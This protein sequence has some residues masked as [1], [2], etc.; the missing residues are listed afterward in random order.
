MLFDYT[1]LQIIWWV[2]IAAVLVIYA[3]TAGFDFGV[4]L[5]MPFLRRKA[6]F[7]ENDEERRVL[8]NTIAPTWDGNQTWL[9]FAGG[10]LF[11][12]WP[13]V[14][15]ATFSGMYAL[16]LCVLWSFFLRP[17]GFDYRSKLPNVNWRRAW[18][19]GL[20][21]SAFLPVLAFGLGMGN[22][23]LGLPI[24]HDPITLRSFYAGN[25]GDLLNLFGIITMVASLFLFLMHGA[26]HLNRR[27]EGA[28]K[29]LFRKM[30]RRF[31][32]AFLLLFSVGWL[33]LAT[34]INGYVYIDAHTIHRGIGV[35]MDNYAQYPW[36][37][38]GPILAY[39]GIV[40]SLLTNGIG[41]GSVAFWLS[42][43]GVAGAVLTPILALFPFV[44]P[45]SVKV[46]QSLTIYNATSAPFTMMG[47]FYITVI[48]LVVIFA[49]KFWGYAMVWRKKKTLSVEDV[50]QHSHHLY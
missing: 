34:N 42:G 15:G 2:L 10:A 6:T 18:D 17:P 24:S 36:K 29:I 50:R 13:P 39:A 35:W 19:W 33:Q 5:L 8:L 14:Y 40:L 3:T 45:S 30:Q 27:T 38:V 25:F 20:F 32:I 49:Y 31:G 28:L 12:I 43:I 48:L 41:R 11:V 4:T 46:A 21:I 26:A 23:L 44:V 22:L 47:M 1:T 7:I 9:V 37:W 16:M